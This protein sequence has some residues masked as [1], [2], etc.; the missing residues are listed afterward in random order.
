[1][2]ASRIT[3]ADARAQ[4]ERFAASSTSF[5][6][7]LNFVQESFID[8][9]THN[10]FVEQ[11]DFGNGTTTGYITLPRQFISCMGVSGD[12]VPVQTYSQFHQYQELGI[13]F[14]LADKITVPGIFDMGDGFCTQG[15]IPQNSYGELRFV[16]SD[17]SDASKPI[18][19][20][21]LDENGT[22]IFDPNGASGIPLLTASPSVT[23]TQLFSK[24]TDLQFPQFKGYV[25][26]FWMNSGVPVQLGYYAPGETRPRYRRYATG[27]VSP[28]I[29]VR[30]LCRRRFIPVVNET[31]WVV[32]GNMRAL[33]LGLQALTQENG[34]RMDLAAAFQANANILLQNNM[35]S[36][37]GSATVRFPFMATFN[38]GM[39]QQTR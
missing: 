20:F 6:S 28:E 21:G 7:D 12:R 24:V 22:E 8:F 2:F 30:M 14:Q 23:T 13:G 9:L 32:P 27:I 35:K 34:S 3:V 19:V 5:I 25:S 36:Y 37:R 29:T 26:L 33:K 39:P 15:D 1:M 16:I 4:L 17:P 38:Q 10:S 31:D 11:V 18:R